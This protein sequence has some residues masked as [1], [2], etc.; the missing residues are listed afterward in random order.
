LHAFTSTSDQHVRVVVA[1]CSFEPLL[2]S[3]VSDFLL[4]AFR[5]P[6]KGRGKRD[7]KAKESERYPGSRTPTIHHSRGMWMVWI[8]FWPFF[9]FL[10]GFLCS[11]ADGYDTLLFPALVRFVFSLSRRERGGFGSGLSS[12]RTRDGWEFFM[13]RFGRYI[14][15][16]WMV[17]PNPC[18]RWFLPLERRF[19]PFCP[20]MN[21]LEN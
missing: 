15:D 19:G 2:T 8:S 9:F 14:S 4:L 11:A 3:H 6:Q 5:E 18:G 20:I 13:Y 10:F 16:R 12:N 7:K 21:I 17:C 1:A